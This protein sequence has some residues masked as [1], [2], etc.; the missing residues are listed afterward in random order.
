MDGRSNGAP[1][2]SDEHVIV[3]AMP[4]RTLAPMFPAALGVN[5]FTSPGPRPFLISAEAGFPGYPGFNPFTSP[6]PRPF[7][8]VTTISSGSAEAGVPGYPPTPQHTNQMPADTVPVSTNNGVAHVGEGSGANGSLHAKKSSK[9]TKN[10]SFNGGD[11]PL[12]STPSAAPSTE[13]KRGRPRLSS[14]QLSSADVGS[15]VVGDSEK[16]SSNKKWKKAKKKPVMSHEELLA[17]PSSSHDARESVEA[18]LMTYDALRR[19]LTQL[20]EGNDKGLSRCPHLKAGTIMTDKDLRANPVRRIGPVPGVEVGDMF[21]FR[22]EMYLT[23]LHI[24]SVAGIDW[25]IVRFE[26]GEDPVALSIVS[27]G[28]YDNVDGDVDVLIYSGQGGAGGSNNKGEKRLPDDQ[29]LERGNLALERSL[30]RSNEI[31]V[32]RCEKDTTGNISKIYIYDGVYKIS[33]S[34]VEKGK[35]G[36][37]LFKYKLLREPDQP[38]GIAVWKRT[39]KWIADPSSRGT[40]IL[41]DISSGIENVPVCLVNDVDDEKGPNHFIYATTMNYPTPLGS[42]KPLQA[43]MCN[44]V[45]LPG[46]TSC[47]C[48]KQN[49]G[50]LPFN[51]NGL[52]VS[53]QPL[54]YECSLSCQ[55]TEN[56]RNRVTQRGIKLHFEV[57][58]TKDRGWGLRSWDPIRAGTFVCEYIGDVIDK[59]K[60]DE[61]GE[62]DEYIFHTMHADDKTFNWNYGPELH[63]GPGILKAPESF[64]PLPIILSAKSVGNVS[65]FMNHSCSPNVFWQPVLYDHSHDAYPHIMFFASKHIPPMTELTYDYGI[66]TGETVGDTGYR[67]PKK[68]LCGSPKCRGFF[69]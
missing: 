64:K 9:S 65:R 14:P 67:S 60:V 47:S 61:D 37:N 8:F 7:A 44:S 26:D 33:E 63:G 55:C 24:Q 30:H 51:S 38:D 21:Y 31:R 29:K 57:F 35:S 10:I 6:A 17:L 52:L 34:W 36:F 68:C 59:I 28:G 46:D 39:Q 56:C 69:G 43:C 23:G 48:A 19:R 1:P 58:R 49:G 27:S 15:S 16:K 40:V 11:N 4:L 20:D 12:S 45:C 25:T 53:R 5:P 50:D 42:E 66:G 54:V 13:K 2:P 41:P 62:E 22:V 18:L 32:I 3:D